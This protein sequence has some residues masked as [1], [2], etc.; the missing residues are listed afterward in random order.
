[1]CVAQ[2]ENGRKGFRFDAMRTLICFC[3]FT[4]LVAA[5][6]QTHTATAKSPQTEGAEI[7]AAETEYERYENTLNVAALK[8]LMVPDAIEVQDEIM[9]RDQIFRLIERFRSMPCH[10][11]PVKMT[12][13]AVTVLSQSVATIVYGATESLVC[14]HGSISFQG[15]ITG[16]WVRKD[17][18]WEAQV[19]HPDN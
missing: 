1:M 18:H 19:Q 15:N 5:R 14:G 11:S 6:A 16:V 17:G 12:D 3:V 9:T 7:M 13:P 4:G 10:W 2:N 8:K